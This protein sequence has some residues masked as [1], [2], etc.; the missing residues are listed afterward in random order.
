[1]QHVDDVSAPRGAFRLLCADTSTGYRRGSGSG[2][3]GEPHERH[4]RVEFDFISQC[5]QRLV[6]SGPNQIDL[7][8]RLG[9]RVSLGYLLDYD[10]S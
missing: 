4:T 9:I 2:W 8:L 1:M 5:H 7:A 10:F 3:K 6:A